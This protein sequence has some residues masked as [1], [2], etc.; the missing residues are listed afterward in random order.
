M[1]MSNEFSHAENAAS[2]IEPVT[3]V[4]D[5]APEEVLKEVMHLEDPEWIADQKK[6]MWRLN[7]IILP[8]VSVLYFFSYLDRGNV[9]NAK[10][11]GFD[12]G[13]KTVYGGV[14]PGLQ[15]LTSPQWQL[16]VM[17]AYVGLV[18]FQ[19]PGCI[20]YRVFPP[21]KWIAFGV[22]GWAVASVL[23]CVAFNLA[24]ELV[25]RI[26]VG[27]FEGLFGTG[28]VYYMSLWYH[29]SELGV[30]VFWFLAPTAL[31]GAFGG[32]LAY[33]I[34]HIKS[35]VPVWKFLFLIEGIPCFCVGIFCL[36]WLP[37]RPMRN[38]RFSGR[39]QEIA[40]ARYHSEDFEK[41]G[42]IQRKHFI[43]VFIDW[44]LYI[45]ALIYVPTAALLASISG[46]L[47]T[48]ISHLG[49]TAPTTANLMSVP[50][51][52]CAF[53]VM[54][55]VSWLSD[56]YR[57]RGLPIIVLATIAGVM[58]ALLGTLPESN[59][60]GKYACVCIAVACVYGTY[61]LTHAWANNN[62]GNE[63]KRSVGMGY[64]TAIGNLGSIAGTWL[65]PASDAPQFRN[66][67]LTCMALSFATGLLTVLNVYLLWRSNR[68]RD[69]LYGK[70]A[71]GVP[72]DLTELAD[73]APHFRY[74]L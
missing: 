37:D 9:A 15:S 27:A 59:L 23:Q 53:V 2:S 14:G 10:L 22:C 52:A 39:Q 60:K 7:S 72:V 20:G 68:R 64:Y 11:Y 24:G 58:Y 67:H 29:R 5:Y 36:Y 25:C 31:A 47:P 32:L 50:P 62:L 42:K 63:T 30:R 8:A 3:D 65:F 55:I 49:Y 73:L 6:Y 4:A 28:I 57:L 71:P 26:A 45:Q 40:V 34:G 16:V 38:S 46:F 1:G 17:I 48:I 35:N 19:V 12:R 43:R 33:G 66:G 44:R 54:Y 41:A 21:S 56:R 51:Y 13:H 74:F 61:P 18:L 69:R 70:P